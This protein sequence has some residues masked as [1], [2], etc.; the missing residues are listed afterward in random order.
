M[1]VDESRRVI[2]GHLNNRAPEWL[3]E[4][5]ELRVVGDEQTWFGRKAVSSWLRRLYDEVL[6]H[7]QTE[8]L[9]LTVD[10]GRGAGEWVLRGRHVGSFVGETPTGRD[11]ALAMACVYDV[12]AGEIVQAR[13]YYDRL[14]LLRQLRIRREIDD[15][16]REG[17][18]W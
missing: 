10:D 2:A 18:L 4:T 14:S 12:A 17:G 8:S 16:N 13:L 5:V 6:D 3:A 1:S 11:V 7:A 9:L 15:R